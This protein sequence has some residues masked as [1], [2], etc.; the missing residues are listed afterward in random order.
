M[1]LFVTQVFD[2][3]QKMVNVTET[4]PQVCS[5]RSTA[6]KTLRME[7]TMIKGTPLLRMVVGLFVALATV[8]MGIYIL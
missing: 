2:D 1:F 8:T 7:G 6:A 4:Q 3:L 5:S